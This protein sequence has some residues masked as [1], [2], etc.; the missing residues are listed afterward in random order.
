MPEYD[1]IVVGAGPNGLAAA[2]ELARNGCKVL[3][4]EGADR[5]GGGTRSE[6]L[7]LP[8]FVHDICSTSYPMGV[9]SPYYSRLPLHEF[10]LEWVYPDV[11]LAHPFDGGHAA[12]MEQ[13]IG[14][15]AAGLGVDGEPYRRLMEPLLENVD[16]LA[17]DI[18]GTFRWMWHPFLMARFGL[19]AARSASGLVKSRFKT[20]EARALF[21]GVAAHSFLR[22]DRAPSAAFGLALMLYGHRN[23]WPFVR[24]GC[25]GLADTL[26]L[27]FESLGGEVQTGW[28]V[29]NVDELPPARAVLLDVTPRQV[30]EM[31]GHRLP[32][33]YRWQL[34]RYRYGAGVFKI[35]WALD[36]PIPWEAPECRRAGVVHLGATLEEMETSERLAAK[37]LHAERPFIL[38]AQASLFDPTRAPEGKHTGWAYC[39]VPSGSKVDMTERI[40]QQVE[41]FAPGFKK[42]ILARNVRYS[43][44]VWAANPN[45]IGGDING[46]KQDI[47]QMIGR[48]ALQFWPYRLSRDG[49]Y[50][51]SSSTPPGGGVH[52]MCG[53]HAARTALR[54]LS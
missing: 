45:Y 44:D 28:W 38:L 42:R 34:S 54:D 5:V 37:G 53:Y 22:L 20:E 8:G 12:V 48:P 40:E 3:L 2:V 51:C 4:V 39:H 35:D 29:K 26:A 18:L 7:T 10:G 13:D 50:L 52:G 27:Y 32:G 11:P 21:A 47:R 19:S 24:G 9:G 1:A 23:N 31:A 17:H 6:A 15:T 41:R 33:Y 49:L 43:H 46:G 25:Q 30:L 16:K 14:A 36:D